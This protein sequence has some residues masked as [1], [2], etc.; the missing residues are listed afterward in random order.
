MKNKTLLILS[1][2]ALSICS[3]TQNQRAKKYGGTATVDLPVNQKLV[4][5]TWK[6][7]QLW[8]LYRPMNSDE[9]P[10]SYTFKEESSYGIIEGEVIFKESK[11]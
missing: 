8:Y 1:I 6:D 4:N 2:V 10:Q 11:N 3:C 9:I 5:A 7:D